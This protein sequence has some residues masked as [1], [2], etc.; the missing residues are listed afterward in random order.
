MSSTCDAL[1]SASTSISAPFSAQANSTSRVTR[2]GSNLEFNGESFRPVG[3][4]IYWLGMSLPAAKMS[5]H[6]FT[7]RL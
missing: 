7:C 5:L 2:D 1:A 3:P 6:P 4:N